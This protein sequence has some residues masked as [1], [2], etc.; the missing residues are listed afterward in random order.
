MAERKFIEVSSDALLP[1][2]L[3][4]RTAALLANSNSTEHKMHYL[5]RST[6]RRKNEPVSRFIPLQEAPSLTPLQEARLKVVDSLKVP[7]KRVVT[8]FDN[9]SK[10]SPEPTAFGIPY[11]MTESGISPQ[12]Q[13]IIVSHGYYGESSSVSLSNRLTT[14]RNKLRSL[15]KVS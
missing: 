7:L 15:K 14:V 4:P 3:T 6:A 2:N 13:P 10:L 9:K 8:L 11:Q 12:F 5:P 1:V